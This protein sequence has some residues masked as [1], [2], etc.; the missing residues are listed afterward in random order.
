M[1]R[2]FKLQLVLDAV[3]KASKSLKDVNKW[4]EKNKQQFRQLGVA[5]AAFTAA[6][7]AGTAFALKKASDLQETQSKFEAVFKEQTPVVEEWARVLQTSFAMSELEAKRNLSAI[8]DLLVPMG[9]ARDNAA[10]LSFEVV[11]LA[12][13]LGSFNNQ[14]TAQVMAD[15]KSALTGMVVPMK[16]YGVVLNEAR[17]K[18]EAMNQ[19]LFSGKGNIDATTK[20]LVI[21][22][23]IAKDSGDAIGDMVKTQKSFANQLKFMLAGLED[24]VVVLGANLLPLF[25]KYLIIINSKIIPAILKFAS[26]TERLEKITIAFTRTIQFMLKVVVGIVSAFDL[27][28]QGM[29]SFFLALTGNFNAAKLGFEELQNKILEYKDVFDEISQATVE[30]TIATNDAIVE[31]NDVAREALLANI[32]SIAQAENKANKARKKGFIEALIS[33]QKFHIE[34]TKVAKDLTK[35]FTSATS[36]GFQ[37]MIKGIGKGW[38]TLA[39]GMTKIAKGLR[40][41]IVKQ[42]SDIAAQWVIKHAIMA[43][44]SVLTAKKEIAASTS[45]G[46][47]KAISAH[48]G[49]PFIGIALGIAA[50]AALVAAI[51][52]F[53]LF[54]DGVRG[55]GGGMAIVGERGPELVNLPR[56]AD[57][58]NNAETRNVLGR[59]GGNGGKMV[60]INID[61]SNS[62]ILGSTFDDF[63]QTVTD[64]IMSDLRLQGNLS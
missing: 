28:G 30:T 59:T 8:Q 7:V 62:Q 22:S 36:A 49:I 50:A 61:L 26:N 12:T 64:G 19:G 47:S 4:V 21:M 63:V 13:D 33:M 54:A 23:L 52:S 53:K 16:K 51:S 3:N 14:P 43:A 32:N 34:W 42:I 45:A 57:V 40:D 6:F 44:A 18:Q 15:I 37:D 11:K 31:S 35:D 55:F 9:L 5:A 20:S 10:K 46:A 58:L 1:A 17:I 56:G 2:T 60:N 27:A 24:T 29:A 25:N 39:D 48:A 41:A 38:D